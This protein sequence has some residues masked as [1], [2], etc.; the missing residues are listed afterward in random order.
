M[1]MPRN[2]FIYGLSEISNMCIVISVINKNLR[3]SFIFMVMYNVLQ[4]CAGIGIFYKCT[5]PLFKIKCNSSLNLD[6]NKILTI[7]FYS[8]FSKFLIIQ[9]GDIESNPGP[10][11]K[12]RTLNSCHWN[13]NS[14]SAH[15]T[16]KKSLIEAY[17]SNHR[18][19]K[20]I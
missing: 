17:N 4:W 18:S 13:G 16:I 10:S 12:Y 6:L 7:F 5:H 3:G 2:L 8:L 15:K 20:L 14:I 9:H 1:L 19:V 11:K